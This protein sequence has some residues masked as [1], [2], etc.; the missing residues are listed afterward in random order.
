MPDA[1]LTRLIRPTNS[2]AIRR[3]DKAFTPHPAVVRRCLMR[4]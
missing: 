1:T 3:P 2:R 4:R